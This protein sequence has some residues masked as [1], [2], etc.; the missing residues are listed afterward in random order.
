LASPFE[1]VAISSVLDASGPTVPTANAVLGSTGDTEMTVSQSG[2]LRR[3]AYMTFAAGSTYIMSTAAYIDR[4]VVIPVS[5]GA[6]AVTLSDGTTAILSIP[7]AS[8]AVDA[9]TYAVPLGIRNTSTAGFKIVTGA[10]V[11]AIAVGGFVGART[12]A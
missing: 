4:L 12:T 10:S 5:T 8:H 3:T 1:L 11:S 9:H 7:A 6:G 2:W